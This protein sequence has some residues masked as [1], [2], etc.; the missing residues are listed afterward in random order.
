MVWLGKPHAISVMFYQAPLHR[1]R[2]VLDYLQWP[3]YTDKT[4]DTAKSTDEI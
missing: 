2:S 1:K 3:K 4:A